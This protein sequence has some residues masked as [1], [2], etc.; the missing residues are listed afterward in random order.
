MSMDYL[1]WLFGLYLLF[2]NLDGFLLM[3]SDKRRAQRGAW[4]VPESSFFL[5]S[6]L[7]GALGVLLGMR[8]WR[9]KTQHTSFTIG[10]PLLLFTNALVILAVLWL[11]LNG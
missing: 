10:I 9:H 11:I 8:R 1:F 6:A 4:R 3:R 2:I 5:I 7:G